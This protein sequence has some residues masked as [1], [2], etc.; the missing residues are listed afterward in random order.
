VTSTPEP[1]PS[2]T[3]LGAALCRFVEQGQPSAS[4]LF[5][6][7]VVERLLDPMLITLAT[8]P[9]Q[10][11][12]LS[13]L[14]P[15]T[16]GAQVMRTRY[17]DEVVTGLVEGGVTQVVILGAGLDTRAYRLPV[18][19]GASVLELDLPATQ[20]YKLRRLG[21]VPALAAG[22]RFVGTDF[23]AEPLGDVLDA[24]GL[25]RGRA[26]LF[27]W[28]GVSQYLTEAAVHSTLACVG[29]SVPGSA[30]VFTY[31]R[32]RVVDGRSGD[33]WSELRQRLEASEPWLFGLEPDQVPG[34]LGA[35][36]L[37]LVDDVGEAEYRVRY[38]EPLGRRLAV[39]DGER[40]ALAVVSRIA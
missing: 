21:A 37:R 6:D 31:V 29:T 4:R 19:A 14:G 2:R 27:V 28:E 7:P 38:A 16:Y 36:G 12:L 32:R 13:E 35:H 39:N 5:F 8:G 17:I 25:D 20:Q 40:A 34:L 15:G 18:L 11:W 1:T 23:T 33:G 10:E 22:V 26:V 9:M 3:A 24:A 30:L